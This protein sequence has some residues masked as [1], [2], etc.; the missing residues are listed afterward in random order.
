MTG[1]LLPCLLLALWSALRDRENSSS[2]SGNLWIIILCYMAAHSFSAHKEFRFLLPILPIFCLLAGQGVQDALTITGKVASRTQNKVEPKLRW[3][4][5]ML[6]ALSNLIPVMYLGLLHQRAPIDVNRHIVSL[7]PP[8]HEPQTYT[9]HYLMGCHSTPLLSHLH[10][11]PTKFE[12][13]Y[14]DCSPTCRSDPDAIC[15]SDLFAQD[16]G[17][18]IEQTYFHCDDFEEG[19]C[20][21]DLR[22]MF[23][24]FVVAFAEHVPS[25][26]SRLSSMGLF[27]VE[28]FTHG[29]NGLRLRLSHNHVIELGKD[30]FSS[31]AFSVVPVIPG[32][33]ELSLDEMVLFASRVL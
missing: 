32:K 28:R 31:G 9:I 14:L 1:L 7:V 26:K 29:I 3:W 27:E 17:R 4:P 2:S 13:W 15:Q 30:N 25:M 18:F 33:V 11:P 8:K 23:P 24:D 21:T 5:L 6:F 20:V 16:P 12:T 10:H 22:I 19:T